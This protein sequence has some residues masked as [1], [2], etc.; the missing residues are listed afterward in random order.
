MEYPEFKYLVEQYKI[1]NS[2]NWKIAEELGLIDI[3]AT[4]EEINFIEQELQVKLPKELVLVFRDYGG[5][6]IAGTEIY[7]AHKNGLFILSQQVPQDILPNFVAVAGNGCG[8]QYGFKVANGV[9]GTEVMFWDH[10]IN[11]EL[12]PTKW[13]TMLEYIAPDVA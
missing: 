6:I 13:K 3:P 1:Q 11:G 10:E 7:S 12:Q 8:D 9:C 4:E 2:A 5:G